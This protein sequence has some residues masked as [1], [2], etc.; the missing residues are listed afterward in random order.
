MPAIGDTVTVN[1]NYGYAD[2]VFAASPNTNFK[3]IDQLPGPAV[4]V[5]GA[6]MPYRGGL[7]DILQPVDILGNLVALPPFSIE[8]D[9]VTIAVGP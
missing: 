7:I 3:I 1:K 5:P 8:D 4:P 6:G 2:G 9:N